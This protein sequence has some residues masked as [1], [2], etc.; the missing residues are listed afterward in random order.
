MGEVQLSHGNRTCCMYVIKMNGYREMQ[1]SFL[2][3]GSLK[4]HDEEF[5]SVMDKSDEETESE[6]DDGGR[7]LCGFV[8]NCSKVSSSSCRGCRGCWGGC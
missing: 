1:V 3:N 5:D 4:V 6:D 8:S 7:G 2:N